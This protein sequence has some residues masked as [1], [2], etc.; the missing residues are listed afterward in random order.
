MNS[1]AVFMYANL[2][3]VLSHNILL[4]ITECPLGS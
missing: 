2:M 4:H 3:S 1:D